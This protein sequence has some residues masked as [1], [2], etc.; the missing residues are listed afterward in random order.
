MGRRTAACRGVFAAIENLFNDSG[1]RFHISEDI[2]KKIW[3]KY[4]LNISMNL[5]QAIIGCGLGGYRDSAYVMDIS[6]KIKGRGSGSGP[7]RRHRYPG[8]KGGE[9]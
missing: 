7:G 8:G 9:L 6:T 3:A 1:V 2:L 5:P 4:A